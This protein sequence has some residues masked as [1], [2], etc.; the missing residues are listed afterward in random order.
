MT[1]DTNQD[2]GRLESEIG[3]LLRVGVVVSTT[4]LV[5]GLLTSISG[6]SARASQVL[7]STAVV[8]LLATPAA[9]V[10]ISVVE[11]ARERDWLFVALTT[12]VLLTLA[13]SVVAAFW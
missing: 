2:A 8:I 7:L 13:G 12:I 4:L 3:R 10:V 11:Y 5:I 6:A 9:R 1:R